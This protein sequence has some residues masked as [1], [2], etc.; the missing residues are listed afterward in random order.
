VDVTWVGESIQYVINKKQS[1]LVIGIVVVSLLGMAVMPYASAS[2][3][4]TRENSSE[5]GVEIGIGQSLSIAI[6]ST[7]SDVEQ[8]V[9]EVS[10]NRE[11]GQASNPQQRAQVL[12]K[13]LN[14]TLQDARDVRA[15]YQS[16]VQE[17]KDGEISQKELVSEISQLANSASRVESNTENIEYAIQFMNNSDLSQVGVTDE[18]I[19]EVRNEVGIVGSEVTRNISTR[20]VAGAEINLNANERAIEATIQS[21]NGS[22]YEARNEEK[23]SY[24]QFNLTA[25]EAI[26]VVEEEFGINTTQFE[27]EA[28]EDDEYN[29]YYKIEAENNT[30][31]YEVIVNGN[32]GEIAEFEKETE[33][34]E[35]DNERR[36]ENRG[37]NGEDEERDNEGEGR[38]EE[39]GNQD[40]MNRNERGDVAS[41]TQGPPPW[42]E[43]E[44]EEDETEEDETEEDETEE[45]EVESELSVEIEEQTDSNATVTVTNGD[46][47]AT[48]VEVLVNGVISGETGADGTI[49]VALPDVPEVE[50]TARDGDRE[51]E[52]ELEQERDDET[53]EDE[54]EENETEENEVESELSIEIEEQTDSNAT[55]LVTDGNETVAGIEVLVNGVI[56]GE[57][58]ADGTI[59]VVLPDVPEVE[60][61]AQD[62][63]R[64]AEVEL[65]QERDDQADNETEEGDIDDSTPVGY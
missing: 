61:T 57:T 18:K 40:E 25:D 20:S 64:E 30:V 2:E 49:D 54:T 53:E 11:L 10:R 24:E 46:E 14:Q 12:S 65:E 35:N 31:E 17:F 39:R 5:G 51:A 19:A 42:A 13:D 41:E 4:E 1:V 60:I 9:D 62:G 43:Y 21:N 23:E 3:H 6:D 38:N 63:D 45:N 22:V 27:V 59:G 28:G 50:I 8:Q 44:E 52:V 55:V 16:T 33:G 29:G 34:E 47:P 15:E 56:S 58:G 7:S 36:G 32:T 48:E 26:E 37:Q